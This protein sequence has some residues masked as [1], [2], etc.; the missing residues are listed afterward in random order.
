MFPN[1][2]KQF[3]LSITYSF[4]SRYDKL[5]RTFKML[6]INK[7]ALYSKSVLGYNSLP[8]ILKYFYDPCIYMDEEEEGVFSHT[9]FY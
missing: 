3:R 6:K 4:S 9:P 5:E 1:I 8:L 2:R 7:W